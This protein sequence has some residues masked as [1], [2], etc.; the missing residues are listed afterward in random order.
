MCLLLIS[1]AVQ[2]SAQSV[3]ALQRHDR[4]GSPFDGLRWH[5]NRPEVLVEDVWYEPLTIEGVTTTSILDVC[6]ERW[7]GKQQKRFGEDLIEAMAIMG[8]ELPETVTLELIRLEDGAPITLTNVAVTEDKRD[9][10]RDAGRSVRRNPPTLAVPAVIPKDQ[11]K[12]DVAEF[13][14]RL[15]DQFAYLH[16]R[17]ID[18]AAELALLEAQL[19]EQVQVADLSAALNELLL[20]F[21]DGHSG[22]HSVHDPEPTHWLPF[23]LSDCGRGLAAS[24]PDRSALLN[25]DFPFLIALDGQPLAR[26][27]DALRPRIAA[28]SPQL[29]RSRALKLLR[30]LNRVR[31]D[32]GLPAG[33]HVRVTLSNKKL[34]GEQVHLNLPL[35]TDRLQSGTW[36]QAPSR[37]LQGQEAH[38]VEGGVGYLRLSRMDDALIPELRRHMQEFK[39]SGGLI[40]DVR[41]NGGGQRGLLLALAGYL[42]PKSAAPVVG[43]VAAY[44]LSPRFDEGHLGGSRHLYRSADPHW[45][46]LQASVIEEFAAAFQPEWELPSGFS[47]WHYLLMDRTEM[48]GEYVYSRPVIVLCNAGC[49]S[50]TDIFLGAL[51][52]LP[53]VTLLG[54]ASS[55]GSARSQ[56]FRLT[57][58]GIEVRCASMASFRPNGQLYDG[59]GV[60]VDIEVFP[61]PQDSLLNGGDAQLDAALRLLSR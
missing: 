37:L 48:P 57:H 17:S 55:G 15:E 3:S 27:L 51:E 12:A 13:G 25:P 10:I 52:C 19:G 44:R 53:Q 42:L 22:V 9:A 4:K 18:L 46:D 11:A 1:L 28:G 35:A 6:E 49:F 50:A 54:T 36:P 20:R 16:L 24:Q 39:Q 60:E 32:L 23:L 34:D 7:P 47:E 58:S 31:R 61:R 38:G 41:D 56:S 21:G 59:N 14:Q 26:W 29:I 5:E 30:D 45:N 8:Y 40:V 33:D 2:V 43:N